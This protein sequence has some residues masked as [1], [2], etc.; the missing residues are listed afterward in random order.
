M[1]F[2]GAAL[3]NDA[4]LERPRQHRRERCAV[5]IDELRSDMRDVLSAAAFAVRPI[6]RDIDARTRS[7]EGG[8]RLKVLVERAV[9]HADQV[10]AVF[11]LELR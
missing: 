4:R 3:D 6:D 7:V 10:A 8:Q 11:G 9:E 2:A 1:I 5:E